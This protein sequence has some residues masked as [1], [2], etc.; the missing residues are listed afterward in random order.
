MTGRLTDR[1]AVVTGGS[2]GLGQAIARKLSSEGADI[3]VADINPADQT[4]EFVEATGR[5]FFSA[6]TDVS[7]E[8]QVNAFAG[9]V[10][11][12]LGLVDIVVNNAGIVP[13]ADFDNVTFEQ[14]KHTF[15]INADG[16]FLTTSA[17]REDLK[18][19][20]AGRVINISAAAYWTTPPP[21]V[22]Y[23]P[24]K[25]A[26]NG[27]THV[28]AAN[29]ASHDVTVNAVAPSLV[30]TDTTLAAVSDEF[31]GHTMQTQDLKRR[32]EPNDIANAVAFLASDEAAFITGQIIVVDGGITRR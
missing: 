6:K 32:G 10:R 28:L 30:Q 2:T 4:R 8:A 3:A 31:F 22:A 15:S 21:M 27:L 1:I 20:S 16:A 24:S 7:D 13:F 19:S 23:V 26:I 18:H 17:F 14:W 11:D 9:E 5:R 25:G 12:A 29:L